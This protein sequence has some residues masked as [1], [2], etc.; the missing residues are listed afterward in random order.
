MSANHSAPTGLA[1]STLTHNQAT[2]ATAVTRPWIKARPPGSW[3]LWPLIIIQ[4]AP[5]WS[6]IR[7]WRGARPGRTRARPPSL[8][9]DEQVSPPV[10]T[11]ARLLVLGADRAL[12]AVADEG[13]AV[14]LDALGDEEAHGGLGPALAQRQVVLVRPSLV[15]V[16]FDQDE[17]VGVVA[18]PLRVAAKDLRIPGPDVVAIEIEMHV[19]ELGDG[20]EL[21]G[22]RWRGQGR[23][24]RRR[25]GARLLS[26]GR[27]SGRRRCH[28]GRRHRRAGGR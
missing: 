4:S 25:R 18:Q 22:H 2:T 19:A 3:W 27:R 8:R 20:R 13:D 10:L 28:G 5:G 17:V 24:R 9:L 7:G 14:G 21:L 12:L 6:I 16:P 15:S 23:R 11:P 1:K 26:G